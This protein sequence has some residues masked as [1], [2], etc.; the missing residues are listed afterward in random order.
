[1]HIDLS[2]R[3]KKA[4]RRAA[5]LLAVFEC[6]KSYL[7]LEVVQDYRKQRERVITLQKV[8]EKYR[9]DKTR[10]VQFTGVETSS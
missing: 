1:M 6:I 7:K 3:T 10:L 4:L 9:D 5:N 2:A 8:L